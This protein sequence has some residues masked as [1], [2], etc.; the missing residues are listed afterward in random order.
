MQLKYLIINSLLI[1]FLSACADQSGMSSLAN[2][3]TASA[4]MGI[5]SGFNM[6]C[7]NVDCQFRRFG[8]EKILYGVPTWHRNDMGISLVG[9]PIMVSA[10][11]EFAAHPEVPVAC[12][13]IRALGAW[14]ENVNVQLVVEGQY[15]VYGMSYD[16]SEDTD[17]VSEHE[18][19]N[20]DA[21]VFP[22]RKSLSNLPWKMFETSVK[23]LKQRGKLTFSLEKTGPGEAVFYFIEVM[24]NYECNGTELEID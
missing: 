3:E 23:T 19:A 2:D 11:D 17:L 24:G 5:P 13:T 10:V 15:G 7:S 8:G 4:D 9:D 18:A 16:E 1:V 14:D 12:Y 22:Y 6:S 21:L 20:E